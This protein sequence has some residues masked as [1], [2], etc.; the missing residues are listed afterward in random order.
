MSGVG[1][2]TGDTP[3]GRHMAARLAQRLAGSNDP[4]RSVLVLKPPTPASH[5]RLAGRVIGRLQR[6]LAAGQDL[7]DTV[8]Q[9][10]SEARKAFFNSAGPLP[11][12]PE[13]C[14][15]RSIARVDVN[16]DETVAWQAAFSARVIVLTGTPIVRAPLLRTA[17]LGVLNMHGSLLPHYRGT[18]V[19]LWQ[20]L[21]DDL[22]KAGLTIHYVD[23][24]VDTGDIIAQF[25][26]AAAA[27]DGPWTIR[28][29]NQVTALDAMPRAVCDVLAGT[30]SRRR[31]DPELGGKIYRYADITPD[32]LKEVIAIMDRRLCV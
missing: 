2:I 5:R 20:V 26:Q 25:P 16:S 23:P 13:G 14:E 32:V 9:Y 18:R 11:D 15:I 4:L 12:W 24:G 30:A 17:S 8:H 10:E 21:N 27:S 6:L 7:S 29:R 28:M 1:L 19:E 22:D 3:L 31:Q